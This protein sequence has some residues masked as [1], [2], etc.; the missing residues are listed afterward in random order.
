MRIGL[1]IHSTAD[2]Y[3]ELFAELSQKWV[4]LG[5]EVHIITGQERSLAEPQVHNCNVKFTHFYSIV[6]WHKEQGTP[7][8]ERTDK[9]GVWMDRGTWLKSKGDYALKVGLDLH[10]DDQIEYA[11]FFPM[12]CTFIWVRDNFDTTIGGLL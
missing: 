8:Y 11:E 1:D 10:F 2:R 9:S 3:P 4:E 12:N 6:D 7:V 5:H